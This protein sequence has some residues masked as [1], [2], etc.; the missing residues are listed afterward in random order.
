VGEMSVGQRDL[1]DLDGGV[2]VQ[3]ILQ[4]RVEEAQLAQDQAVAEQR[5]VM[6]DDEALEE[7]GIDLRE[8]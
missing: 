4:R 5:S 8:I 2:D 3:E 7:F 1:D 6:T